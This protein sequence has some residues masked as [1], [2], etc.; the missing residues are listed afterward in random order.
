[1]AR[2][3]VVWD[4]RTIDEQAQVC[5]SLM[6]MCPAGDLPL[7]GTLRQLFLDHLDFKGD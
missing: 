4:L 2:A 5:T 1:M 3:E 7:P 6:L